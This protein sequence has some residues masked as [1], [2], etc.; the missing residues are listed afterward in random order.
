MIDSGYTKLHG[1]ILDSSVWRESKETRLVWVTMLAMANRQGFVGA[2][3]PGLADRARV[4]LEECQEALRVFLGPDQWSRNKKD[5]GRR[6]EECGGG[7]RIL[8]FLEYRDRMGI[9]D[10]RE[11]KRAWQ[12]E[13]RRRKK[14]GLEE[15]KRG[16]ARA[17]VADGLAEAQAVPRENP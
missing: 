12:A 13:Y 14:E 5:D 11:Y 4:T 9:E 8:N 10:R 2:A 16:G 3:V 6:I 7:W 15:A 1:S 17:A